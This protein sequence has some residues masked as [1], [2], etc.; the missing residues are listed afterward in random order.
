MLIK[1]LLFILLGGFIF[2]GKA[3]VSW[4]NENVF[5][6]HEENSKEIKAELK[7]N[8]VLFNIK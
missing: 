1:V 5:K 7:K 6:S 8:L 3:E 4:L 2:A